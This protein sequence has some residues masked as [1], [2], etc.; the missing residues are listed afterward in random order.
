M[1][2]FVYCLV[3]QRTQMACEALLEEVLN[4]AA[5]FGLA[6]NLKTMSTD[7]ELAAIKLYSVVAPVVRCAQFLFHLC[8]SVW[9]SAAPRNGSALQK[10]CRWL[11][12]QSDAACSPFVLAHQRSMRCLCVLE[13]TLPARSFPPAA[14]VGGQLPVWKITPPCWPC[15]D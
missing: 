7:F 4:F 2:P 10:L 1:F 8:Q 13:T 9:R 6:L 5:D 12:H 15:P 14:M 11:R 3:T